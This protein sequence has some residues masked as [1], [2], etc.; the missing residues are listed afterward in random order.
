MII[1]KT[2]NISKYTSLGEK[3]QKAFTFIIDPELL[4]LEPGRYEIDG[5][6]VYALISEYIPKDLSEGKFE[7]HKKYID[8][9]FVAKGEELIGYAPYEGQK[10]LSGYNDVKDISFFEGDKSFIKIGHGMFALFFPDELHMP[11]I[12]TQNPNPVKKVVV[13]IKA[14]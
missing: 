1:D 11:G 13:K 14:E 2:D 4:F 10:I 6:V 5:E 8:L 3:F 12:K 9:Q 7:S